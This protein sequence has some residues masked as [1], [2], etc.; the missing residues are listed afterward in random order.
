MFSFGGQ[1]ALGLSNFGTST[2]F[3]C[4]VNEKNNKYE[5]GILILLALCRGNNNFDQ[6]RAKDK[7]YKLPR[8][9]LFKKQ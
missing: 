3:I 6:E 9:T 4:H 2:T 7:H 5:Q 8:I 1:K